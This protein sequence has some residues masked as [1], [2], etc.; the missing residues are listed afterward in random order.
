MLG[1]FLGAQDTLDRDRRLN[2]H[3]LFEQKQLGVL[4]NEFKPPARYIS[5]RQKPWNQLE[6]SFPW[7]YRYNEV[8]P[9]YLTT[10]KLPKAVGLI[11]I[12]SKFE[13]LTLWKRLVEFESNYP[14]RAVGLIFCDPGSPKAYVV[15]N[16]NIARE[17][18]RAIID[19]QWSLDPYE[20]FVKPLGKLVDGDVKLPENEGCDE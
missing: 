1:D 19:D 14:G 12:L 15:H 9:V 11:E 6:F 7:F 3:E 13:T 5:D 16:S 8:F 18:W 4:L 20:E 17:T 2:K 10:Y